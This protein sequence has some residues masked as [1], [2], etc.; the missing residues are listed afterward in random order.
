MRR[1]RIALAAFVLALGA[2]VAA[3]SPA[4]LHEIGEPIRHHVRS[5]RPGVD[6]ALDGLLAN[7]VVVDG[8]WTDALDL[9]LAHP[10]LAVV[11]RTG[12]RFSNAGWRAGAGTSAG[13]HLGSSFLTLGFKPTQARP[14]FVY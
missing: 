9:A 1:I 4:L 6:R 13:H 5:N 10:A 12:D 8:L 11:T 14:Y 3:P 2:T 7:V